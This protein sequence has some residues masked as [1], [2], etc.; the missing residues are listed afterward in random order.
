MPARTM[1]IWASGNSI[2]LALLAAWRS[3][4]GDAC[5]F[6]LCHKAHET[7]QLGPCIGLIRLVRPGKMGEDSL[8]L[9]V[10][11][12]L[13]LLDFFDAL[14]RI[15]KADPVHARI[16]AN[17]NMYGL[18]GFL[19]RSGKDFSGLIAE[20]PPDGSPAATISR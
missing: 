5:S 3:L 12:L 19:R 10:F 20:R 1:S 7:E 15:R 2:M 4:K 17:M 6:Q 18:P 11:Q 16:Q 14:R 8:Q 13:D 9:H